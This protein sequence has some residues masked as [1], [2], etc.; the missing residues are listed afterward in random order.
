MDLH[1]IIAGLTRLPG[2]SCEGF[3]LH[4]RGSEVDYNLT[5]NYMGLRDNDEGWTITFEGH[6]F[7]AQRVGSLRSASTPERMSGTYMWVP[8]ARAHGGKLVLQFT[9]IEAVRRYP[10]LMDVIAE[11]DGGVCATSWGPVAYAFE[12]FIPCRE[13]ARIAMLRRNIEEGWASSSQ[14][15]EMPRALAQP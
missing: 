5:R 10:L 8:E 6:T 13:G 9:D 2:R 4:L 15:Y 11:T 7:S 14:L 12:P 1:D 3:V